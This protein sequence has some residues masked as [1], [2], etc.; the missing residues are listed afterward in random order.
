MFEKEEKQLQNLKQHYD[1]IPIPASIDERIL[2]G[3]HRAKKKKRFSS[4]KW[5]SL[6][7]GLFIVILLT[8]IRVSP[9]FAGYIS[10]IPG[11]EKIVEL[12][13]FDK[14]L[15][16]AIEN[17]FYQEINVSQEH[18]G[19]N[20]TIDGAIVDEQKMVLFYT[21]ESN[22]DID[23]VFPD[24]IKL[25]DENGKDIEKIGFSYGGF[26]DLIKGQPVANTIDF[27]FEEQNFPESLILS[28]KLSELDSTWEI[29]FTIDQSKYQ[30]MKEVIPLNETV[31][32]EGQKITFDK[33]TILPTR[34]AVQLKYDEANTKQIF[35][36]EDLRLIDEN[37]ERWNGISNGISA[38]HL[39][40]N[41]RIIYLQSNYFKKPKELY[42]EFSSVRA[43]D[44]DELEVVVDTATNE[45]L[46]APKDG[47]L[48]SVEKRGHDL[49]F[50]LNSSHPSDENF[51]YSLF[52]HDYR[53]QAGN[54]YSSNSSFSSDSPDGKQIGL[55]LENLEFTNPLT[56]TIV[57]YPSRITEAVRIKIK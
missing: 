50:L 19:I 15:M 9:T 26:Q 30:G 57:D 17:D 33:V 23:S 51:H 8:S 36:F 38:S 4:V 44:K 48:S 37:G 10:N 2:K 22:R 54:E 35:A 13:R 24:K 12:V 49:A 43:L 6:A 18:Q 14:G 39:S 20:I 53:D 45:L 25:Q 16:S 55:V 52:S 31:S 41:E 21:L 27:H 56:F 3:I 42:L 32:I 46:K 5:G 7:A 11:L 47:M 29:P 34:V 28:V 40:N 1:D